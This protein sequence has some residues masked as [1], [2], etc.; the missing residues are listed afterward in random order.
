MT[1]IACAH[2][3][4]PVVTARAGTGPAFCCY[5]CYLVS[6]IVGTQGERG[7]HAWNLL[8]LALGAVLAM[9]VM[10]ISLLL[11]TGGV[12]PGAAPLF[13]WTMLALAT[14]AMLLL[15]YPFA[16][17]AWREL[18]ARRPSLDTLIAL[19]AFAAFGVSAAN[20]QRG[21][22]PVYFDTATM[23]PVLVTFGKLIEATAKQRT[24]QLV[25]GLETL[26]PR[27]A[28]RLDPAGV[29]EVELAQLRAGDRQQRQ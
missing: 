13:R 12:D 15:A 18:A 3:G 25:H 9:N 22:G 26:L 11:Y 14:P 17:G 21:A 23:L 6:R 5:G 10:M 4:L 16:R 7:V 24:G 27:T 8:R 1:R 28:L 20:A 2:C 29:C 19:G